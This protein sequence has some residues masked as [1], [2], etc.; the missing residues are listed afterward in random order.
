MGRLRLV[1]GAGEE[2]E[3]FGGGEFDL[4]GGG[5]V[6]GDLFEERGGVLVLEEAKGDE[7]DD[8]DLGVLVPGGG[9]L[10]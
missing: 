9:M 7:G 10:S 8:P 3:G 5:G 6:G 1:G 2:I 4:F